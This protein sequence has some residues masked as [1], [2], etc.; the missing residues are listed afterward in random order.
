M[1]TPVVEMNVRE[2]ITKLRKLHVSTMER[3][4]HAH[5]QLRIAEDEN[6]SDSWQY[7]EAFYE[8]WCKAAGIFAAIKE[9]EQYT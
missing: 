1:E 7:E 2:A 3:A 8:T 6:W 5:T 9:L 4:M